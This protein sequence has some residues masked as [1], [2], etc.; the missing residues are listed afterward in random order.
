MN[1]CMENY[2]ILTTMKLNVKLDIDPGT[3]AE[4]A[5]QL[6]TRDFFR[7]R[8]LIESKARLRFKNSMLKAR[9]EFQKNGLKRIDL[10]TALAEIRGKKR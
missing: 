8:A 1:I 10:E 6:P 5:D 4:M 2:S 3:I 7:V 9:G